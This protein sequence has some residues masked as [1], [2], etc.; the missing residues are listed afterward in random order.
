M[1]CY[2]TYQLWKGFQKI[3]IVIIS[4]YILFA[5]EVR[6]RRWKMQ[7]VNMCLTTF[8]TFINRAPFI[9]EKRCQVMRFRKLV[10]A[11]RHERWT[12]TTVWHWKVLVKVRKV[13]KR[14]G[15]N[16]VHLPFAKQLVLMVCSSKCDERWKMANEMGRNQ[17]ISAPLCFTWRSRLSSEVS[18]RWQL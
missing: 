1:N 17:F 10:I 16:T 2:E 18:S 15:K 14:G 5:R 13:E 8:S 7:V 4:N 3:A 9:S 11:I 6:R 12:V